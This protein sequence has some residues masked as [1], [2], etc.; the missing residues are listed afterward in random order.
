MAEQV[1]MA[2]RD[3]FE[4]VSATPSGLP[5]APW[6]PGLFAPFSTVLLALQRLGRSWRLLVAVELGMAIAVA[7]LATA[8]FYSDVVASVQLQSTLASAP[9]TDRNI[10]IDV[11]ANDIHLLER[12]NVDA[13]VRA[14]AAQSL[15]SFT[16]GS[17]EYVDIM[18]PL[19]AT[20]INGAATSA[21]VGFICENQFVYDACQQGQIL[22]MAYNLAQAAPYMNVS[23]GRLPRETTGSALAEVAVTPG[24]GVK[25][26]S[27]LHFIDPADGSAQPSGFDVRVVGVWFPKDE[28][29][30][31]WNGKGF[32]TIPPPPVG[33]GPPAQYPV[34][35]TDGA[36]F[37]NLNYAATATRPPMGVGLHYVYFTAPD[38]INAAQA[39][40]IQSQ[41]TA[42]HTRLGPDIAGS[43]GATNVGVGTHLGDLLGS[44]VALLANQ[45]MPLYSIDA[46]LVA[47][48]L[49]FIFV[50]SGL[51]IE[52]QSGEIA[53]LKSRGASATQIML[54]YLTQG[55]LLAAV[56]L[57]VGMAAAGG[58]AMALVRYFVPLS[59]TV[60]ASL[61]P[62]Y[63]ASALS[64]NDALVPA[65]IGAGL[66]ALALALATWQAARLDALAFRR[67]QGRRAREPFWKRY[68]LD[69]GLVVLCGAGYAEL[70]SFGGLSTRAQLNSLNTGPAP[71]DYVQIAA[72]SLL[73]LAGA[74]VLQRVMPLALRQ[75]AW[76]A[77]RGRSATG[78]LAFAQVTRASS[79]FNRLTLLLTL[80]VG[81][82]LF[83]LTFQTTIAR[84]ATDDANYTVAAN[85]RVV[86]KPQ[87]EGTQST[88][89]F[90][91]KFAKMPGVQ[92][93]S[94][95]YRG[96][97]LT[98]PNQGGQ[99]I[100]ILGVDPATF[101]QTAIWRSDYASQS[102]PSLMRILA[103]GPH[104]DTTGESGQ[105]L[106]AL[107]DQTYANNF[108]LRV[109]DRFQFSPQEAGQNDTSS[110]AYLVVGGIVNAF[111]SL[112][113]EYSAGY[114]IVD[115]NDYLNV[116]ANPNIAAYTVNGPNEYLLRTTPDARAARLRATALTDP[117][118]F[119]Q[120]ELDARTLAQTYRTDPLAAGMSGLLLLGALIAALL[121]LVGVLTQASI[122]ARQRQTQ[123]AVLR[124]LGLS[125]GA[126]TRVLLSEQAL[127]YLVGVLAGVVIAALLAVASLPF[128]GFS[129]AAYAPPVIGVPSSLLAVNR[130]GSLIYLG[131]LLGAF[132][133]ALIVAALLARWTGLSDALRV[134]ED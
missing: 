19:F 107:I 36:L 85:E 90:A 87:S 31:F 65:A 132:V 114:V 120:S 84:S 91:A 64:L 55:V 129:T 58:L 61:T 76:L 8:P 98:L 101:A 3:E 32:D 24:M 75:G 60:R 16:R 18:R 47:L 66:G 105:P 35:F 89:D 54:I 108:N 74:L 12:H 10:Q 80:A 6:R 39:R 82:G 93:V 33:N 100:D 43:Y 70:L 45:A 13:T 81:L 57:L 20:Q 68:Y 42:F 77:A 21:E 48:A 106:V 27:I 92:R 99:N 121:A 97:A 22:P 23:A 122:G 63:I 73:L 37:H 130:E 96:I 51:L 109:G 30:P 40:S 28:T 4:G 72:P 46:Q 117:N 124:T 111:P 113:D 104:S 34:L 62:A 112:Y 133:V 119:V 69:L 94:P 53:T 125:R 116:L 59:A 52:S 78:M 103:R 131:I 67:E 44:V 26:G 86:I 11:N 14:D 29:D 102:L 41:L 128:L 115:V 79:A 95:L 1:E 123:F 71:V 126:L 110:S 118:F 9:S 7:L 5:H 2:K 25:P 15:G 83:S 56:A 88:L 49:L 127:V 134:G 38:R 17:T 50:M